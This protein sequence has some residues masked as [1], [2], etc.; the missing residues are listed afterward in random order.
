[1]KPFWSSHNGQTTLTIYQGD[2]VEVLRQVPGESIH[3]VITSPPF[4]GLRSY[5]SETEVLWADGWRGQLGLEPVP[6]LYVQH[7]VEVFR[8]VRRVL[9]RDGTLW[10]N[11]G[12]AYASNPG[13]RN[14]VGGFQANPSLERSAAESAMSHLKRGPGIKSKDLLMMP[15]RVALALQADGWWLRADII[16][17]KPNPMP[18]SVTDRPTKS[19]EYVFLLAKAER[20][21]YDAEAIKEP[22]SDS[23]LAAIERGP[24]EPPDGGYQHDAHN[25]FGKT[26]GNRAFSDP[27][28]LERI[29]AGRNKRTVWAIATES[30]SEAHFATFPQKLVEPCILA[31]TSEKG[32]CPECGAPW[33]R[34]VEL[35]GGRT[36]GRTPERLAAV[37]RAGKVGDGASFGSGLR[38]EDISERKTIGWHPA[39]AHDLPPVPCTI[40]DPFT[41]SGTTLLVAQRLG[42]NGIGIEMNPAYCEM[43]RRRLEA[44]HIQ[45]R[46]GV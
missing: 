13:D 5:G 9:R 25:R 10:L 38:Q 22:I 41:G 46:L 45:Q 33:K 39:C 37:K 32:R 30:Y 31:G 3:C 7:L 18:E 21:F 24:R 12:D 19:H 42:R 27:A 40:L 11:M 15:A 35:V 43:A 20:Y 17:S 26:S 2:A 28:S 23:M 6:D 1:M 14:K 29:R 36:S 44:E 34:V 8:E 4:W 16:W